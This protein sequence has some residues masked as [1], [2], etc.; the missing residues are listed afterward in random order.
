MQTSLAAAK[1][2]LSSGISDGLNGR[3]DAS[4]SPSYYDSEDN[5]SGIQTPVQITPARIGTN[6]RESNTVVSDSIVNLSNEFELRKQNFDSDAKAI[7][8]V[9]PGRPP[10]KQIEDYKNLKKNFEMWKK[11]YK[12]RLREAKTTL[13][14]SV[15]AESGGGGGDGGGRGSGGDRRSRHWWGKLSK[16]G[17]DRIA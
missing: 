12:H 15:Y 17:K 2:T 16:R 3:P 4:P 7:V 9:N 13:V 1:K 14:K 10:S 11:D 8:V 5:I 6:R